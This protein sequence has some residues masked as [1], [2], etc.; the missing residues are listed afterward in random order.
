MDCFLDEDCLPCSMVCSGSGKK[1]KSKQCVETT[2]TF[3]AEPSFAELDSTSNES[4][5]D[6]KGKQKI[7]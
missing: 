3:F 4:K 5:Q 7:D 6:K 1:P 2:S